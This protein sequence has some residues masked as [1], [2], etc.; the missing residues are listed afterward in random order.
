[1]RK[2]LIYIIL[3]A[4]AVAVIG[5]AIWWY[6]SQERIEVRVSTEEARLN[7]W[8]AV[9]ILF[10]SRNLDVKQEFPFF[11][12]VIP[13]TR[14]TIV[15]RH[16]PY[17]IETAKQ[18]SVLERWVRDG[19]TL[20]YRVTG[21]WD[22]EESERSF[23]QL[24]PMNL[25]V[26]LMR[27]ELVEAESY[28]STTMP[29]CPDQSQEI[30]FAN[31]PPLKMQ[32]NP[33][34]ESIFDLDHVAQGL[35][36]LTLGVGMLQLNYGSG[37]V[38]FVRELRQWTNSYVSCYDNA[39]ILYSIVSDFGQSSTRPSPRTLWILPMG[40]FP[41][42]FE[43]IWKNAPHA[44]LGVALAFLVLI[45][46]WNIRQSPPAYEVSSPRRSAY[47]YA[48]SAAKF[49]WRNGDLRAYLI[50]L[51]TNA[52]RGHP[53]DLRDRIIS[54]TAKRLGISEI[55]LREAL[56]PEKRAPSESELIE[57]V[58]LVQALYKKG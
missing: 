47:E 36:P 18:S 7:P 23:Q 43:L 48:T 17:T 10:E 58:R 9:S 57:Q 40:A 34:G 42:L 4:A 3:S 38:F 24:F 8:L 13:S 11:N 29:E 25:G 21:V 32:A 37:R 56:K 31:R 45:L 46:V 12:E 39:Y 44:V 5:I 1:M 22:E 30:T 28:I 6:R 35:R 2:A 54:D 20:I 55:K 33:I 52:L 49:A 26:H 15:V 16:G 19:G 14:D 53:L 41:S 51:G 27:K 50:A